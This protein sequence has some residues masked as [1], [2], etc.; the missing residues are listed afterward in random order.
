VSIVFRTHTDSPHY[1]ELPLEEDAADPPDPE[2]K[3]FEQRLESALRAN[4]GVL[5]LGVGDRAAPAAPKE[6]M[7]LLKKP[8]S[9]FLPGFGVAKPRVQRDYLYG[10]RVIIKGFE[11]ASGRIEIRPFNPLRIAFQYNMEV[12][13]CPVLYAEG[14][15]SS[16][17]IRIGSILVGAYG[18]QGM[19]QEI[20]AIPSSA[21]KLIIAEEETEIAHLEEVAVE[22]LDRSAPDPTWREHAGVRNVTLIQGSAIAIALPPPN[23]NRELR[24]RVRGYYTNFVRETRYHSATGAERQ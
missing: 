1:A 4:G 10:R 20:H 23:Q 13:S 7:L 17:P 12:G 8:A 24:L 18:E 9:S 21:T 14:S 16:E 2:R 11:T 19:R 3:A 5:N 6:L 15:D 22:T